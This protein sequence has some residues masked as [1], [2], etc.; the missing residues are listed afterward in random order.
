MYKPFFSTLAARGKSNIQQPKGKTMKRKIF[1]GILLTVAAFLGLATTPAF[2]VPDTPPAPPASCSQVTVGTGAWPLGKHV[3]K[4][5]GGATVANANLMLGVLNSAPLGRF[6]TEMIGLAGNSNRGNF[7]LY[8]TYAHAVA[9]FGGIPHWQNPDAGA[10]G[11]TF[12]DPSGI[13]LFTVI[14][15][16]NGKLVNNAFIANTTAHELGHWGDAIVG[17]ALNRQ[18]KVTLGGTKTTG[19][20][21][22]LTITNGNI[23]GSPVSLPVTSV[24]ADTLITIASKFASAVNANGALTAAGLTATSSGETFTISYTGAGSGPTYNYTVS[25]SATEQIFLDTVATKASSTNL[26]GHSLH[27]AVPE[28]VTIGGTVTTGNQLKLTLTDT[29]FGTQSVLVSAVAGDTLTTLSTKLK[30]AINT[31]LG[32]SGINATSAG[33][34]VSITSATGHITEY[35]GAVLVGTAVST[36]ETLALLADIPT[37]NTK[38]PDCTAANTGVFNERLD[39]NSKYICS[40]KETGTVAGTVSNGTIALTITDAIAEPT[41]THQVV[42]SVPVSVGQT[43]A[44]IAGNVATAINGNAKLSGA[45]ISATHAAGSADV[46][47]VSASGLATTFAYSTGGTTVTMNLSVPGYGRNDSF[48]IKSGYINGDTNWNNLNLAWPNFFSNSA[49]VFAENFAILLG[50]EDK[51]FPATGNTNF[52][53]LDWYF[54]FNPAFQ[55][56]RNVINAGANTLLPPTAFPSGCPT[57]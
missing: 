8:D 35:G 14:F 39:S 10:A 33:A 20:T 41:G 18:Q 9:D 49:E 55:C 17:S 34:V 37:F 12:N 22:T 45:K 46:V 32:A 3:Y 5:G 11:F 24:A 19:D 51:S 27:F 28:T 1:S 47:I 13:P 26:F 54:D 57:N 56:I 48:S 52:Q 30:N 50:K 36:T 25:G 38:V 2:A 15:Q 23:A 43:F 29:A 4:C 16:Q 21:I 40:T 53:S 44:T 42:V 7:Y 6:S 31:A